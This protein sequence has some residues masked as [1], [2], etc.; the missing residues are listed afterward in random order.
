MIL[1][2]YPKCSTCQKALKFL[3]E[4]NISFT[5]TIRNI[6]EH[7]PSLDELEKML[8]Y[9]EGHVKKLF[10][11]SG[12]LY[13]Q[14]NLSEKLADLTISDALNLLNQNGMLVKRPFFIGHHFG[15]IGFNEEKWN[16]AL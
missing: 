13:R 6:K 8:E 2:I 7:P 16:Q 5:F 12:E 10:N 11:T 15:L 4:K 1:Y 9:Q 14:L 3:N